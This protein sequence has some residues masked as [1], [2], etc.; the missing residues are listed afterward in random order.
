MKICLVSQEYPPETAWGGVGTQTWVKARALARLGHEVHVLSRAADQELETRSEL[1]DG[2]MVHRM[3][4]PGFAFPI[5]GKPLYMLGYT[6]YV[7][8][9]LY[10]LMEQYKFDVFDFPEFGGEG[11]AYQLDRVLWNWVPVVVQLHGPLAMFREI[12]RWP[13]PHSRLQQFGMFVEEFSL[14]NADVIMSCS[15]SVADLAHRYYGIAR[16]AVEVVHCGVDTSIFHPVPE[17]PLESR[18]TVLFVG[19]IVENKGAHIV[20]DA[21]LSL[22]HKY[23]GIKLKLLGSGSEVP[24][25][26]RARCKAEEADDCVEF[27]GFVPLHELPDYYRRAHVFCSPSEYEGFG[28]VY[29]ESMACGCPVIASTEG[30]GVEAIEDGAT[31]LLVPPN[32]IQATAAALDRILGDSALRHRM[33][34][35]G[36]QRVADYFSMEKY[37]Q[38]VV[39]AYEKAIEICRHIPDDV[40][41]LSD[42][43]ATY[44]M[45]R[46][47][48]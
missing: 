7:L 5:Y 22:R 13:E 23:P 46:E 19:Q 15:G 36:K 27:C 17:T 4:P 33:S 32:D 10:Q 8:A 38:R 3:Q 47:P 31:G 9:A 44:H 20:A 41:N 35:A 34:E 42:W 39:A 1:I 30:G 11:F 16:D 6:W 26:I 21:V 43:E 14:K 2:V 37:I 29:I 48:S 24:D 28:Q 45:R 18:P 40:K 25:M 12:F